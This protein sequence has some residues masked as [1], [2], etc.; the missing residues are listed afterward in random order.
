[1]QS[2]R[3]R[4]LLVILITGLVLIFVLQV[5]KAAAWQGSVVEMF[6][7]ENAWWEMTPSVIWESETFKMEI[8]IVGR[9]DVQRAGVTDL[10]PAAWGLNRGDGIAETVAEFFDDGTHGDEVAG[11]RIFT[12]D[13]VSADYVRWI[14]GGGKSWGFWD[15]FLRV[16]YKNGT[17]AESYFPM[18]LGVV[19]AK[20]QDVFTVKDFGDG[21]SS[22]A[23]AFFIDDSK[24]EV[25]NDYPVANVFCGTSNFMAYKKL[26][27]VFPDE[28]DFATVVPGMQLFQPGSFGE[29]VPY[30]VTVSNA[31]QNIGLPI[32]DNSSAF[33][34]S[35]RLKA[36]I[37]HSFGDVSIIDHE[38]AHAWGASIGSSFGLLE[39]EN[40]QE[41]HWKDSSDIGGQLA[42]YYF[43][44]FNGYVGH[45][46]YNADET[47]HLIANTEK[48]APYSPL[49]LY[50]MGLIPPEEVPP[51]HI[52]NAPDLSNL[53]SITAESVTTVTIEDIIN[54]E[55]GAREPSYLDSQ[56][57]FNMAFIVTQDVPYSDAA[58]AYFS[59]MAYDLTA[60]KT[61]GQN[62]FFVPFYWATGGRATLTTRLPVD[63]PDPVLTQPTPTAKPT[64]TASSSMPTE[65]LTLAVEPEDA[66][67]SDEV[68]A[69]GIPWSSLAG[70]GFLI[71]FGL[72]VVLRKKK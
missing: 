1:M 27:S 50:V 45:F 6:P 62:R 15:G 65:S 40:S 25:M 68:S 69:V 4:T 2:A 60:E 51:I 31:V 59:L 64:Q 26:Y 54:A 38:I 8:H 33:G 28:F 21:L 7:Q 56:K 18:R 16:Q 46:A 44:D 19:S 23:Y 5:K 55:G 30:E 36:V 11:D 20:Y 43:D 71:V 72:W 49:E 48:D 12:R 14:G 10:E 52:L 29:N 3:T 24:H 47:W 22:T 53:E 57:D 41:I 63:L 9:S 70:I 39:D 32:F 58:Y 42:A 66:N 17:Y 61:T 34:S 67:E 37:F 13:D 35:E